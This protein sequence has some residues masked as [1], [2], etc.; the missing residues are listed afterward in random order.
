VW[1]GAIIKDFIEGRIMGY[2]LTFS[3]LKN[4]INGISL[5]KQ[6]PSKSC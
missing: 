6:Y 2:S 5:K 1:G 3:I 4:L